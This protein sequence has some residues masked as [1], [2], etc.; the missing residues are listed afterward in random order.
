MSASSSEGTDG[1]DTFDYVMVDFWD[2]HVDF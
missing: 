2:Q 1:W